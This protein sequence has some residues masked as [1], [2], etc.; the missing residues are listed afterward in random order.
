[1]A[2]SIIVKNLF[3]FIV[4]IVFLLFNM[5]FFAVFYPLDGDGTRKVA[6]TQKN[7]QKKVFI[8]DEKSSL[9]L[10]YIGIADE[11]KRTSPRST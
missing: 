1:M 2:A 6:E 10:N 3:V 9:Y 5:Q 4:F 7:F 11:K 8:P